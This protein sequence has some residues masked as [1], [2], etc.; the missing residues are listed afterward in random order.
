VYAGGISKS[1]KEAVES[2]GDRV[3]PRFIRDLFDNPQAMDAGDKGTG[4]SVDF[5]THPGG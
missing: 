2:D 4:E 3:S 5:Q 1:D